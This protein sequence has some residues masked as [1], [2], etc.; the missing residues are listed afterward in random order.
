MKNNS[1]V[2]AA[3]A[4]A[5]LLAVSA[6]AFAAKSGGDNLVMPAD[7]LKWE[8]GPVKG[9]HVA[10]LWGDWLKGGPYGV[11]IKFDAG[12]MHSLHH[13]TQTMKTVIIS[14]TFVFKPEGGTETKLG[15]GSYLK[16]QGGKK[17]VSGCSAE[18]ECVFF[19]TASDKF[20]YLDDSGAGAK[21][22]K[23]DDGAAKAEKK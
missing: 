23:K 9:T 17:H 14:G 6:G 20:D 19:V 2:V 10:K 7:S 16:Q 3:I 22:E 4:G 15:P 5:A 18:S 8:D 12:L 1:R 11:L 13:H 21:E